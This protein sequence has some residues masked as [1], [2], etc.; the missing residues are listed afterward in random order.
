LCACHFQ[1]KRYLTWL[2]HSY[3]V[4]LATCNLYNCL[5]QPMK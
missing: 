4:S 3:G 1:I 2:S 5:P